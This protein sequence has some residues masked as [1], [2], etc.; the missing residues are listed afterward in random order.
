LKAKWNSA[1]SDVE[2]NYLVVVKDLTDLQQ[3]ANNVASSVSHPDSTQTSAGRSLWDQV[4]ILH[5][6]AVEQFQSRSQSVE[7]STANVSAVSQGYTLLHTSVTVVEHTISSTAT[8]LQQCL[9]QVETT[10]QSFDTRFARLLPI[11][12]QLQ[13]ARPATASTSTAPDPAILNQIQDL[14]LQVWKLQDTLWTQ[15]LQPTPT[16]SSPSTTKATL[17]DMQAQLKLLQVRIVSDGIQI[18]TRVFQSFDDVQAWVVS[19]LPTRHYGLFVDAVSLL[20]FFTSIEHFEAE[21]TFSSFYNQSKSG[22]ASMYEARVA[23]SIQNLSPMVFG[24]SNASGLDASDCLPAVTNPEKWDNGST[25]LHYQIS[26][27]M[28]DVKYQLESTI[29]S[30]FANYQDA[31]Q[32]AHECL[33]KS[34]RFVMELCSFMTQD[35]NKWKHHGHSNK[36]AWRMTSVCMRRIFEEIHSEHVIAKD[37]YD[38]SDRDF[39][40]ARFLWATWK[41]HAVMAKYLK[42]QFYEHPSIA[43]VLAHHLA[44]NYVKPDDNVSS[45]VKDL[46]KQLKTYTPKI[47]YLINKDPDSG[48][49]N[50]R[51][52]KQ[53]QVKK[54]QA[55]DRN[56][57]G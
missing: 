54:D 2:A 27:S 42:H 4:K 36:E 38:Q 18:G 23:A 37:V 44:D 46:E 32:I 6:T 15:S 13:T 29:D 43:A 53:D 41:A 45:K 20:D 11:S 10:L 25:G 52:S 50:K 12:K 40:T 51:K 8:A 47:D 7:A 57:T 33:Y 24:K 19:D 16:P 9:L 17:L 26:R 14:Q 31:R 28:D 39:S 34:K 56:G 3:F 5:S 22:F 55:K 30:V 21:K 49:G 48:P 1:F 35:F